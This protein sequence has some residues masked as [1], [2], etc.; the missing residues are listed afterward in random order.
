MLS[1]LSYAPI[2]V[3]RPGCL[4]LTG[5]KQYIIISA[6]LCQVFFLFFYD[7]FYFVFC[8][9]VACSAKAAF[10]LNFRQF[11]YHIF[12]LFFIYGA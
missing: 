8:E 4:A 10:H 5:D 11:A 6:L 1:Q 9:L 3:Y 7:F 2:L 12:K